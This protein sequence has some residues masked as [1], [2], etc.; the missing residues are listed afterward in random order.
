MRFITCL[1]GLVVVAGVVLTAGAVDAARH[2]A[3]RPGVLTA[4]HQPVAAEAC[5]VTVI[6]PHIPVFRPSPS[7]TP[8]PAPPA[9]APAGAPP[10]ARPGPPGVVVNSP[11]QALINQ[12]RARGGL[13]PLTW[14]SCLAGVAR[15]QAAHLA[16]PG[17]PFQHYGGVQQDLGCRLGPQVGENIGWYS[18]GPSDSWMNSKFVASPE[19]YANIM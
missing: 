8:A 4:A 14:S 2:P 1:G 11:Q 13:P 9:A 17:V 12:D 3:A 16:T 15:A 6:P 19:H 18:A 5:C 10:Q 7:P